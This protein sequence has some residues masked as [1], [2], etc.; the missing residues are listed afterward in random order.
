M[1]ILLRSRML[2]GAREK[3]EEWM[4]HSR[5]WARCP[6]ECRMYEHHF[7]VLGARLCVC[8]FVSS[9]RKDWR[10]FWPRGNAGNAKHQW[11]G[12]V[13]SVQT[14]VLSLWDLRQVA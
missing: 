13:T 5:N 6:P 7:Q 12:Q 8:L 11:C 1:S 9:E 14:P 4:A 10:A 3:R 2:T